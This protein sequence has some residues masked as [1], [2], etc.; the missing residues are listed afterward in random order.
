MTYK[1]RNSGTCSTQVQFDLESGKI[2]NVIFTGGCSGN[3]KA[4]S[5]L[6][7]G[8]EAAE[9]VNK[10]KGLRCGFKSTSCPDQLS[11]A[12]EEALETL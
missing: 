7:E 11:R 10:L 12:I 1:R 6:L 4:I 3:L 5:S 2:Y 8:M 9:A